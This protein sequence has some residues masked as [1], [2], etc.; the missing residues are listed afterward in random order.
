ML[1]ERVV[2][3]ARVEDTVGQWVGESQNGVPNGVEQ[4]GGLAGESSTGAHTNN[5]SI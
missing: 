1:R 2:C 4:D 5:A 3:G